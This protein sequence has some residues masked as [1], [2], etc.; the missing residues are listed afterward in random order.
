MK[1]R[2]GFLLV[3]VLMVATCPTPSLGQTGEK[4]GLQVDL[5]LGFTSGLDAKEALGLSN[6]DESTGATLRFGATYKL[7]IMPNLFLNPTFQM[8]FFNEE[9][10]FGGAEVSIGGQGYNLNTL[11]WKT[12]QI[13]FG[14]NPTYY[15]MPPSAKFRAYGGLGL[16]LNMNSFG[17]IDVDTRQG[18]GTIEGPDGKTSL[19][20]G[21]M[22]GFDY[23][24]NNGMSI[25]FILQYDLLFAE[26]MSNVFLISTGTIFYF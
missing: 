11:K 2:V 18:T 16:K 15:F 21:P 25:P 1:Q 3:I 17:D 19:A 14:V 5:G 9:L 26:D 23:L 13:N 7:P 22:I 8:S 10:D 20:L 12:T 6:L 24:L 4:S